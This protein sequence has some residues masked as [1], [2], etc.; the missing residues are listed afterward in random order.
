M[1]NVLLIN[2]NVS[3]I[4][5]KSARKFNTKSLQSLYT[6]LLGVDG[7]CGMV[8]IE[9]ESVDVCV[10]GCCCAKKGEEKEREMG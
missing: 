3:A 6:N 2:P 7:G 5:T 4:D 1:I 10:D 9:L 8:S